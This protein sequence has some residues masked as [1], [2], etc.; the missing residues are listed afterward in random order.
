[1]YNSK[2]HEINIVKNKNL[3]FKFE[4]YNKLNLWTDGAKNDKNVSTAFWLM[5]TKQKQDMAWNC[6]EKHIYTAE[7]TDILAAL[8]YIEKSECKKWI[9]VTDS[10]SI[11]QALANPSFSSKTNYT[12]HDITRKEKYYHLTVNGWDMI[13]FWTLSHIGVLGNEE[14][15]SL[16]TYISNTSDNVPV[17]NIEIPETD[18]V[19][20]LKETLTKKWTLY[21][22]ETLHNKETWYHNINAKTTQPWFVKRNFIHRNFYTTIRRLRIGHGR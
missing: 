21:W 18:C 20:I 2:F 16:A 3:H 4:V 5:I 12:I 6:Q 1:M 17:K 11:L 22:N 19:N 8:E 13:L 15:D 9:V 7:A 10:R 14:A